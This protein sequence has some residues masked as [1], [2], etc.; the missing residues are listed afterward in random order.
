MIHVRIKTKT[1]MK[2]DKKPVLV[3]VKIEHQSEV[4]SLFY[5]VEFSTCVAGRS[6]K[7]DTVLDS[8]SATGSEFQRVGPK[9]S[10][11]DSNTSKRERGGEVREQR[12]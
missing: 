2:M 10:R 7:T 9:Y 1:L 3:R 8:V 6:F 12:E 4:S 5:L 11:L